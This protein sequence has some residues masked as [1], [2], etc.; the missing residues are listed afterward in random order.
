[1]TD[2]QI[3]AAARKL[4]EL[5]GQDPNKQTTRNPK[6]GP[7]GVVYDIAIYCYMWEIAVDEIRGR[8]MMDE[9]I[10]YASALN[11]EDF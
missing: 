11:H 5:R 7:G 9:A 2:P 1:M 3:E 10:A 8:L 4:C 6:P